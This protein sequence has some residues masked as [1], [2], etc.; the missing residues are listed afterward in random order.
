MGWKELICVFFEIIYYINIY[1]YIYIIYIY[2]IQYACM[3]V[4]K[5]CIQ[6]CVSIVIYGSMVPHDMVLSDDIN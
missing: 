6:M 4:I 5:L 1:K 3:Y 2:N